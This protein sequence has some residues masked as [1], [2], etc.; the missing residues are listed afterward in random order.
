MAA[1]APFF[2][3][4]YNTTDEVRA[5]AQGFITVQAIFLPV[6]AFM[7]ACYFTLRSGGRTI[8][9]LLFDSVFVW[10]VSIPLARFLTGMTG[11]PIIGIFFCCQA[12]ELIKC[13]VG[14]VLLVKGVWLQNIVSG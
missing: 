9:T 13:A 11:M 12:V 7:H 8:V 14:T 10:A 2:P 3:K 6:Q 4:I 1:V 5:L